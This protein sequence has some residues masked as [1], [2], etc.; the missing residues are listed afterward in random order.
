M[1]YIV[2]DFH[3]CIITEFSILL[4]LLRA[5]INNLDKG[6]CIAYVFLNFFKLKKKI[7]SMLKQ[8]NLYQKTALCTKCSQAIASE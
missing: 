7:K 6:T 4:I 2:C 1:C 5:D 3:G 8:I